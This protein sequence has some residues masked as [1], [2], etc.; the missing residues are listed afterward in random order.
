MT[1]RQQFHWKGLHVP[2]IAPWSEEKPLPYKVIKRVGPD[3][4]EGIGYA[5]EV[6]SA[7]RRDGNLWVRWPALRGRGKPRL[8][9]IHPLRQRQ[10]MSH[11]LCMVCAASTFNDEFRQW[12]GKHLFIGRAVD[13]RPIRDG[14]RTD[15]PPVC[16]PCAV[17]AAEACPHLVKGHTAA[18]VERAEPWGVAGIV[19]DPRTL[20][21]IPTRNKN[22]LTDVAFEDPTL[23]WTL[24]ARDVVTLHGCTPVNLADLA[25]PS[26]AA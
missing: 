20:R 21:P 18:L 4:V 5:D 8:A 12:G 24:A 1:A 15:T 23:R 26:V 19:Y 10:A 2:F 3:G 6:S 9:D 16:L 7:D 14:E 25:T 17:E 22:G 11:M 13:G